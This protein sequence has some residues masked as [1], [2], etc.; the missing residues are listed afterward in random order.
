MKYIIIL[1]SFTL[2]FLII[3]LNKKNNFELIKI[4]KYTNY[5]YI[6][7]PYN[8]IMT[9]DD[10]PSSYIFEI[11][12]KNNFPK[13]YE[14]TCELQ[15]YFGVNNIVFGIKKK[16]NK[17]TF[18]Y[19]LYYCNYNEKHKIQNV[20]DFFNISQNINFENYY[21]I[22]FELE[23]NNLNLEELNIYNTLVKCNC[24][25][26][27]K[28]NEAFNICYNCLEC[29]NVSY[30]IKLNKIINKN[31]Y[32]FFYRDRTNNNDVLEYSKTLFG[33]DVNLELIFKLYLLTC[34]TSI[35]IT[36]KTNC[37]GLYFSSITFDNFINDFSL[38]T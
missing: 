32:K 22:S 28:Y 15:K 24:K 31:I 4:K 11:F 21:L 16:D 29:A 2:I 6:N 27:V 20:F 26:L 36:K 38:N 1:L 14:K 19:Y 37:I 35:C 17:Y 33:N 12:T 5:N 30:D 23:E 34:D 8:A 25:K 9:E 3:K 13:I 18:E 7:E 10:L